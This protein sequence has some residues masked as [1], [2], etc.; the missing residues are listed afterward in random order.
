M[1]I[2]MFGWEYPPYNSGGLG[3]A[4]KGIVDALTN[5]GAE[6]LFV[7]PKKTE[8]N[9]DRVKFLFGRQN[10]KNV[11]RSYVDNLLDAYQ[12]DTHYAKK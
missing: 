10:N 4:C 7:L 2:L 12:T 5:N 9:D 11:K 6:I 1:K 8:V 3:V